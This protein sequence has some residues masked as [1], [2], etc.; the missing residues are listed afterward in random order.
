MGAVLDG[1]SFY[2]LQ[3]Y[4]EQIKPGRNLTSERR[5]GRNNAKHTVAC[6]NISY[7]FTVNKGLNVKWDK[8]GQTI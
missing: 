7:F 6:D 3:T 8:Q 1:F 2:R 4:P 5:D